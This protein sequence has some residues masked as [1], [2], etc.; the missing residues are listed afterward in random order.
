MKIK[1]W[2][3]DENDVFVLKLVIRVISR[4]KSIEKLLNLHRIHG[5]HV[6]S[7]FSVLSRFREATLK[8]FLVWCPN[9]AN[10]VVSHAFTEQLSQIC[11]YYF[12][13][14]AKC[15]KVIYTGYVRPVN[16][17]ITPIR[18]IR[19]FCDGSDHFDVE[20][21]V[22]W[23]LLDDERPSFCWS[24]LCFRMMVVSISQK[25]AGDSCVLSISFVL[26]SAKMYVRTCVNYTVFRREKNEFN[27]IDKTEWFWYVR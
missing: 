24:K 15:L 19:E 23:C 16:D 12:P 21:R 5:L 17:S 11:W 27:P 25:F 10:K 18:V 22:D 3:I 6:W 8:V 20:L 13:V 14:Y 26:I 4:C 1:T 9:N 2:L 7:Y